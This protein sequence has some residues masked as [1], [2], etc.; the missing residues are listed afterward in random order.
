MLR[1]RNTDGRK[2][3]HS[4]A[5]QDKYVNISPGN[6]RDIV[7]GAMVGLGFHNR[8]NACDS[9]R[10]DLRASDKDRSSAERFDADDPPEFCAKG[11]NC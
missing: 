5:F 1:E 11:A 2:S 4:I 6:K 9:L 8:E 10:Q 7:N 3:F